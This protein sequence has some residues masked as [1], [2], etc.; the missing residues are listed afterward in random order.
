MK[1]TK[2]DQPIKFGRREYAGVSK[3]IPL[4][5]DGSDHWNVCRHD[6]WKHMTPAQVLAQCEE[7][8]PAFWTA[9]NGRGGYKVLR[10]MP[11]H[12]VQPEGEL[13]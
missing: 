6:K 8:L 3:W 11:A 1:C 13:F 12:L 2:C 10:K 7:T 5:L 9:P 4:S